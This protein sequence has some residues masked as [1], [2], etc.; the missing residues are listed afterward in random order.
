[1]SG[2]E[3]T[4]EFQVSVERDVMVPMRDGVG[5]ATDVHRPAR[6]GQALDGPFPVLLQRT[7]YSKDGEALALEAAFFT[8]RGYV[9]VLQDCRG[10]Y[11][12][13]G[14]F[15]KKLSQKSLLPWWEKLG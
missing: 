5:L 13:E 12:S 8:S 4:A 14:G 6:D 9:T 7:P 3:T 15:T 10:R 2:K 11:K 1:M